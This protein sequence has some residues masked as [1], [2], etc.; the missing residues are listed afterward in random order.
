MD[1]RKERTEVLS[2]VDVQKAERLQMAAA[3][4]GGYT[5][6]VVGGQGDLFT[7]TLDTNERNNVTTKIME[8]PQNK[9]IVSMQNTANPKSQTDLAEL[10][11][12]ER[13]SAQQQTSE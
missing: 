13:D 9:V 4:L 1:M 12:A 8:V 11:Q 7:L 3:N 10:L 6:K 2:L 5:V